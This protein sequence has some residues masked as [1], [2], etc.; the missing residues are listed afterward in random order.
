MPPRE[1]EPY[2]GRPVAF[3]ATERWPGLRPRRRPA[4]AALAAALVLHAAVFALALVFVRAQPRAPLE[5]EAVQ[6]VFA[7]PATQAAP[8]NS[9]TATE[10]TPAPEPTP[11]AVTPPPE[12]EPPSA[13]AVQ[14][15]EP[16]PQAVTPPTE[17]QQ[18]V[19]PAARPPEPPPT[20]TAMPPL[21]EPPPPPPRPEPVERL[22]RPPKPELRAPRRTNVVAKPG[23]PATREA[24]PG[25]SASAAAPAQPAVEVP[26]AADWQRELAAWMAAHKTYPE[27]ARRRGQ[28]G[29][30]ELRFTADRSGRVLSVSLVRSAGSD[31][32]DSAAEAMVR[33]ATL[34]PFPP[35]MTQQTVT[36]TVTIRYSLED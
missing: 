36:V 3:I 15:P 30:V 1:A 25:S 11:Q 29:S 34:P 22:A 9:P 5:D 23:A 32:L 2:A 19:E 10:A 28:Q 17:P 27:L 8:E 35:T 6:L 33:N 31:L 20:E 24:Q 26:I 21:P 18:S 4:V 16:T 13:P 7:P 12:T 14:A